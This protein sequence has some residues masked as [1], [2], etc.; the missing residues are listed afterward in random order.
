MIYNSI[1]S[2]TLVW[3]L[4]ETVSILSILVLT[5]SEILNSSI[6]IPFNLNDIFKKIWKI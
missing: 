4:S 1:N 6:L 5:S 3:L 2:L